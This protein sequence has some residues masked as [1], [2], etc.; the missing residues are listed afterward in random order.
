MNR[1]LEFIYTRFVLALL[2]NREYKANLI[3]TFL[4]DISVFF[5]TFTLYMI[6]EQTT[7]ISNWTVLHYITFFALALLNGKIVFMFGGRQLE[8]EILLG[9]L[10]SVLTKPI[11][12]WAYILT[13]RFNGAV[14]FSGLFL[15]FSLVIIV[16]YVQNINV[17]ILTVMIFGILY[18]LLIELI[19]ALLSFFIIRTDI[20]GVPI[21]RTI[22]FF[23]DYLPLFLKGAPF[24][25][26]LGI[27]PSVI[28]AF[29]VVELVRNNYTYLYLI[30]YSIFSAILL[31]PTAILLY[32]KGVQRYEAFG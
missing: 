8:Q 16:L 3:M 2:E 11:S 10:N 23:E 26:F 15:S 13:L 19:L 24:F 25:R 1:N 20:V 6:L 29:L 14:L 32:V 30:H 17:I 4:F 27:I 5:A 9:N 7:T 28:Y 22:W 21:R 12:L 31:I 18:S